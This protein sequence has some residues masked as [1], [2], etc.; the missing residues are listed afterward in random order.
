[1]QTPL[2]PMDFTCESQRMCDNGLVQF[3][4]EEMDA[5][6]TPLENAGMSFPTCPSH[7]S[8]FYR[9][10]P[11][12]EVVDHVTPIAVS[13]YEAEKPRFEHSSDDDE[14]PTVAVIEITEDLAQHVPTC[15]TTMAGADG[16]ASTLR[17]D[18]SP[19]EQMLTSEDASTGEEE[20]TLSSRAA[21]PEKSKAPSVNPTRFHTEKVDV[22]EVVEVV[23]EDSEEEVA[24]E[25]AQFTEETRTA[26]VCEE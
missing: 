12:P 23:S 15:L 11:Y 7:T 8:S 1:M 16:I 25:E 13:A 26:V 10:D 3:Q 17:V 21:T 2:T 20:D 24:V 6:R 9:Y 4:L 14:D 22:G 18:H 19:S 5:L